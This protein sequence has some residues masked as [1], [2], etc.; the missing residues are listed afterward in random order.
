VPNKILLQA[1]AA[2]P[3]AYA[4]F[5]YVATNADAPRL[6]WWANWGWIAVIAFM[7]GGFFYIRAQER[8]QR[9]PS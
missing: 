2:V 1:V 7:V 4:L 9:P 5:W 8:R 3:W 6:A